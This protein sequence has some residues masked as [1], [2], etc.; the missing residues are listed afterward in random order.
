VM[1]LLLV[2]APVSALAVAAGAEAG[3][4]CARTARNAPIVRAYLVAG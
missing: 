3:T 2:I 4:T 1:R